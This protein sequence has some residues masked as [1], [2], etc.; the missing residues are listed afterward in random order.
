M[1]RALAAALLALW[2]GA[3]PA[4]IVTDAAGLREIAGGLIAA[5][6]AEAARD[7]AQ[8]LLA[9]DPG[10]VAALL[11]LARAHV[12][13]GTPRDALAPAWRA[14]RLARGEARFVAARLL[15]RAHA[16]LGQDTRAQIWLRLARGDA[17]DA[18]AVAA[19]A[20]DFRAIRARNPLRLTLSFGIA[21]SSN[22]NGGSSEESFTLPGL[23]FEFVL[24]G[25]ARALSGWRFAAAGT[26]A[27]RLH[28][29]ERSATFLEA[30]LSGRTYVL[31][32]EARAQAPEAEG[33]DFADIAWSQG[34]VHRWMSAGASGPSAAGASVA[35]SWFDGALYSRAVALTWDRQFRAGPRD[36]LSLSA[37]IDWTERR[38]RDDGEVFVEDYASLGGRLRWQ[39]QVETGRLSLSLGLRD[40]LSEIPDTAYSGVTLG[41]GHDWARPLGELRLGLSA[42]IDW[43]SY[44]A[45]VYTWGTREDLRG[46][47]RASVGLAEWE[48]WGFSPV[49]TLEASRTDSDV[50]RFDQRRLSLDLGLRSSF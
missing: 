19:V 16:D 42:E 34:I 35:A 36:R 30:A 11:L 43:R 20:E 29:G 27:W 12:E 18:A 14:W 6:E 1:R 32:E 10:D 3:A 23:P 47:L 5:G 9:R 44:D 33:S 26:L 8:A 24:D 40:H 15:A 45:S 25:E 48:L 50:A 21:P 4:Q 37:F 17:P 2:A 22:I 46:T 13:A 39:R 31:S 38:D 41:I 49:A 28:S 7:L